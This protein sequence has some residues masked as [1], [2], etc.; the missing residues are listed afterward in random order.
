MLLPTVCLL[1]PAG[2]PLTQCS[3]RRGLGAYCAPSLKTRLC[4]VFLQGGS[5]VRLAAGATV[6]DDDSVG[7]STEVDGGGFCL[8]VAL[9]GNLEVWVAPMTAG[10]LAVG[11]FNRSPAAAEIVASWADLG[12]AATARFDAV[13]VWSGASAGKALRG[14]VSANTAHHS[15][16]L[17]VLTPSAEV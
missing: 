3:A 1:F 2:W 6:H 10:R 8:D 12:L 13:D 9:G 16:T 4:R 11:L 5:T 14:R 17:L 15:L 7:H